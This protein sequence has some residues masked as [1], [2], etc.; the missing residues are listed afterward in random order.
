MILLARPESSREF[1]EGL[2]RDREKDM[3][4]IKNFLERIDDPKI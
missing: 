2:I 4:N 3:R 1:S